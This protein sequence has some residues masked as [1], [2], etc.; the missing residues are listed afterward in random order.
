MQKRAPEKIYFENIGGSFQFRAKSAADLKKILSL[1][2]TVWAALC[3]PAASL[4]G[5]P[6]FFKALDGDADGMIR[7]DE[8]K[9]AIVWMLNIL[10]DVTAVDGTQGAIPVSALNPDFPDGKQLIDFFAANQSELDNGSGMVEMSAVRAK[11][12]A[13]STGAL[14]G[15]GMLR[16][17]AVE[18]T[19]A[20]PLYN[21]ITTLLGCQDKLTLDILEKFLTDAAN[22]SALQ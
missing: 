21:D 4:N 2:E 6:A 16:I 3:V 17:K 1:D 19:P 15:D 5:D 22:F 8:V 18:N 20:L 13:V 7:A 11:L 12:S 9:K 10:S 14:T